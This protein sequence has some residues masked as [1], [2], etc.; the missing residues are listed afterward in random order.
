MTSTIQKQYII[1]TVSTGAITVPSDGV[2]G[3]LSVDASKNGYTPIGI[4]GSDK[5]GGASGYCIVTVFYIDGNDISYQVRNTINVQ[6][7]PTI[8]FYVLYERS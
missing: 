6:A 3:S 1:G 7:T 2:T 8:I 4:I 5:K